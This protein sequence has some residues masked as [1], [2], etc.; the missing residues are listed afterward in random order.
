MYED[1]LR[2]LLRLQL[3]TQEELPEERNVLEGKVNYS[4]PEQVLDNTGISA[5]AQQIA[6]A[7]ANSAAA[8]PPKPSV[9][10]TQTIVKDK[11]DPFANV[12]RNDPCPCGSGKK[13]KK[14]HGR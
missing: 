4:A 6:S 9:G 2:T 13:F 10:K 11:D 5:G 1:F 14:C 7:A 3:A 8:P 12:G